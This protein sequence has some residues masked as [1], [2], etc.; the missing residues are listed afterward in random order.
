MPT[1]EGH[2]VAGRYRL[3]QRIGSGAMGVVWQAHDE[4]LHRT[5]A[6]K[7]LLPQPGLSSAQAEEARLRSMREGRIAAR[8]QHPN[9]ITVYDV[10]E[11]GGQPWLI[12]EY[13]PSD[14][15]AVVLAERGSL[16]PRE[17][18]GIGAQVAAALTAAHAAGI[19]HRDIKPANVLLANDGTVKITDFGIS[20]AVGDVTVT[21]TGMLAGTPA[22][23]A[24]EVA[25]GEQPA[26]AADV[27]S[28]GSTLYT[29]IEGHSPFG[30]SENTLALLH[31]VA[32]GK[33][34]PP[35][36]AGPL[37]ALLM[38][39][40]R[41]DPAQRPTMPE[42]MESLRAIAEGRSP[43]SGSVAAMV[44]GY[45]APSVPRPSPAVPAPSP[46]LPQHLPP[47][48]RT[49]LDPNPLAEPAG[50]GSAPR[51]AAPIGAA[52]IGMAMGSAPPPPASAP[53]TRRARVRQAI[54]TA[55]AIIA[56]AAAG[57]LVATLL[58]NK[59]E[60][61][62]SQAPPGSSAAP[63]P[64]SNQSAT[65]TA[66]AA[67]AT[68][69]AAQSPEANEQLVIRFYQLL[70]EQLGQAWAL[71]SPNAQSN[72]P[73]RYEGFAG[74]WNSIADVEASDVRST[75]QNTV[76]VKVTYTLKDGRKADERWWFRV[77]ARNG[78]LL[79]DAYDRQRGNGR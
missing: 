38:Q 70:P 18:A 11:D 25:K 20:R 51:G 14:S 6:V 56:A 34:N 55:L 33:V 8:L 5:V 19:V 76:R 39:L 4:R 74:W 28:L 61:T 43:S 15:L 13:L 75:D 64:I 12:M 46:H 72:T 23:L 3:G 44:P 37:T 2:L 41:L 62:T 30:L 32:A 16:P 42:A 22:Y 58:S 69:T 35:R 29:A 26:P 10:A 60:G 67:A 73:G 63:T 53:S 17:V 27:F 45:P 50:G 24:P 79:I 7:Q 49:R 65:P 57:V 40:L 68:R 36:Q 21:A 31:A 54:L 47:R 9:A 59:S 48:E 71:F 52:P 1:E 66:T 77:V 78:T